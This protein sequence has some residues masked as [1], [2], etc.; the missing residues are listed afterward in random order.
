MKRIPGVIIKGGASL[1]FTVLWLAT[2]GASSSDSSTT[3]LFSEPAKTFHQSI[4]LGNGRIGAMVF[5]GVTEERIVLNESSLWSGSPADNDRDEAYKSLPEIRRLL[6]EGNNPE[7]ADLVMKNF[8]CKGAGSG[9]G[10]GANVPFGCYQTLGDLKLT[11]GDTPMSNYS[12]TLDLRS[13]V[14]TVRYESNGVKFERAHFISA[15]D[16]V[17]VSRFN[18]DHASSLSFTIS[19]DRKERFQTVAVNDRELLMTG[20]LNDGRGGKGVSYAGRIRVLAKG[21]IVKA[22]ANRLVVERADEVILL[23]AAATD[24]RG[25]AGRQLAD[26]AGATL[27]DLDKAAKKSFAKLRAA[28]KSD[29]EKWFDRVALNLNDGSPSPNAALPMAQRLVGFAKGVRDPELAALYFNFGR[30]LLISSSRPGGLPANLQGIWA[31][32]IQTPWNGD[33]HLDIN[34]QMNYWPAQVG[35]LSELQEP[36]NKLIASLVVPGRKTA[37]AY[38]NSRGWIAH[39]ITNPWGFTAPGE[40]A[41]WGATTS[42]S[43]WLCEHLWTQYAYT[44]D[45]KF[46]AWAYPIMKECALFYLD[47]IWEE[48]DHH[49]LVTGPSNSPENSFKLPDGR[50]AQVCMGPTIDMQLLRELFSNTT[51]AAEILGIDEDLRRELE[52]KR[53][54]IAPNQIGP[55]GRLQEWLKPYPEPEPHH[56]HVSPL[57]GLH[58]Y[59]EISPTRTPELA[60][61]TRK[62]LEVRGDEGT[63]WSLAWKINFWARLGDGD[64]AYK[65]LQMLLRPVKS[66]AVNMQGGGGSAENLFCFHP[67][68]QIDGNFGGCA[69]IA[70]MLMQSTGDA[71]PVIHFLPALPSAWPTGS[72]RGLRACGGIEVDLCWKDGHATSATLK[73]TSD[74]PVQ[75]LPPKGQAIAAVTRKGAPV[76]AALDADGSSVIQTK[77]GQ[78]YV[79]GFKAKH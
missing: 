72:F 19:M 64:R 2:V 47:N 7:A 44:R 66:S 76:P 60:Q 48:P 36:M 40:H 18:A 30:Y 29:H 42:G 73:A 33:W 70:E 5:G 28:Q 54:R 16:Q 53:A 68:F 13:A 79:V 45:R 17:F 37:K 39:V 41:S 78:T 14:G 27:N 12:R 22:D 75:I 26:P 20:T 65:L 49:W 9:H 8:T 10:S 52:Q 71:T 35:N 43:A 51:R 34:V 24:F 23:F 6:A 38:Y 77:R 61:A 4:P 57:Y 3:L 58:P 56:R 21:G 11:F 46:L 15:P 62:L 67:P 69:G 63:G 25:F 74:G 31:E 59:D 55:D 32:E 1:C 50:T